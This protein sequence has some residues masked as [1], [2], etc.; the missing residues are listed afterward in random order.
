MRRIAQYQSGEIHSKL[1]ETVEI[2][3]RILHVTG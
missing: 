3:R 2:A 1:V